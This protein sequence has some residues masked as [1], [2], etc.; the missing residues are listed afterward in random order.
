MLAIK[1]PP[2]IKSILVGSELGRRRGKVFLCGVKD[3]QDIR[4]ALVDDFLILRHYL[5]R[6]H[7]RVF[8]IGDKDAAE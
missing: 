2:I 4:A 3:G 7:V 5:F 1:A 8:V 6:K